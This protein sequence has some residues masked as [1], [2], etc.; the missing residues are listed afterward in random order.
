[1]LSKGAVMNFE[2]MK[3]AFANGDVCLMECFDTKEQAVV[4]VVCA[5]Q[6]SG[7][8]IEMVPFAKLFNDNPYEQLMPPDPTTTG[9]ITN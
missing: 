2:T 4:A 6:R 1:M 7:G 8:D 3:K 9:F 5:V